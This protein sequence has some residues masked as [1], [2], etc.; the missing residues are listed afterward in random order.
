MGIPIV[1]LATV[2]LWLWA[3]NSYSKSS[4][5]CTLGEGI[6]DITYTSLY[7]VFT[8]PYSVPFV[9]DTMHARM[10]A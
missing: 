7:N 9:Q 5:R 3:Q 8:H 6:G 2:A 1:S 4:F 10:I